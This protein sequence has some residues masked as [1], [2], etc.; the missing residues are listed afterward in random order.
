[1][2]KPTAFTKEAT[3]GVF[4]IKGLEKHTLPDVLNAVFSMDDKGDKAL[5]ELLA[6]VKS[7]M[8]LGDSVTMVKLEGNLLSYI[9]NN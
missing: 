6:Q 2:S 9:I 4:D 7:I 5:K 3:T 8:D 1:M